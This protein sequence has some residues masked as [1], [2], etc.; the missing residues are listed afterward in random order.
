MTQ[1]K[2][3]DLAAA[4]ADAGFSCTVTIGKEGECTVRVLAV[5]LISAEILVLGE[6]GERHG[7]DMHLINGDGL[8]YFAKRET[9]HA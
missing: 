9:S 6:V 4:V 3:Y 5:R 2:A 7:C 8:T 1:S